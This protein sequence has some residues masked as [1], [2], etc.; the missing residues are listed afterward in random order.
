M[1]GRGPKAYDYY[2]D[3]A[4]RA[5]YLLVG[6]I[7]A[8]I[9][10]FWKAEE[11][12]KLGLN[13]ATLHL[14]GLIFLLVAM[15][16]ALSRLHQQPFV[17]AKMAEDLD[18]ADER[19]QLVQSAAQGQSVVGS[20]GVLHPQD[21]VERIQEL[22]QNRIAVQ[23]AMEKVNERCKRLYKIRNRLLVFG[24]GLLLAERI[25]IPYYKG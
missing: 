9:A 8:S 14:A 10:F 17:F 7:A 18:L 20:Y 3:L 2:K 15:M 6:I 5:E 22:D 13:P 11:P 24:Y 12:A 19:V 16:V 23:A 4:Q 1:P 21:Q 25:W